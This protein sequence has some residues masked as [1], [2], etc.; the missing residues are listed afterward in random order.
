GQVVGLLGFRDILDGVEGD[1]AVRLREVLQERDHA[2]ERSRLTLQLAER[3]IDASLEGI[4][5]TDARGRIEFINPA[6]THLTGYTLEEVSG[7]TPAVL[8]S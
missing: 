5:I 4:M 7:R 3:V 6:F 2:L 1:Y 8:S